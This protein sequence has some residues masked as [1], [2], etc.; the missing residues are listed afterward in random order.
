MSY[1]ISIVH[2]SSL[3]G[4]VQPVYQAIWASNTDFDEV[5]I[6]PT[7]VQDHMPDKVFAA[8]Q[9]V[10]PLRSPWSPPTNAVHTVLCSHTHVLE[11]GFFWHTLPLIKNNNI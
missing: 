2:Y 11:E 4:S 3:C 9:K 10:L 8:L 6:S 7:M 1:F 5:L